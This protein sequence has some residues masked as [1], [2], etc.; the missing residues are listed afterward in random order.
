MPSPVLTRRT[1]LAAGL[2]LAAAPHA[3]GKPVRGQSCVQRTD[4]PGDRRRVD[5]QAAPV[6]RRASR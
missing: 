2:G 6:V 1:A 3:V 5:G 4:P